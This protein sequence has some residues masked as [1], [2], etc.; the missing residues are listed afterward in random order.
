MK[1]DTLI[2]VTKDLRERLKEFAKKS[3]TYTM[4]LERLLDI[5]E[6]KEN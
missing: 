2:P 5:A 3:E 6:G 4:V 1:N